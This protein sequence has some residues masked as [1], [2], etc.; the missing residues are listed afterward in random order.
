MGFDYCDKKES[1][2]TTP[3]A[4]DEFVSG[5]LYDKTTSVSKTPVLIRE[6]LGKN[7]RFYKTGDLL[8]KEFRRDRVNVEVTAVD[9][10]SK[11]VDIWFG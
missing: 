1:A 2:I 6:L 11:I 4:K 10:D 5:I 9:G 3:E 7:G 8:T